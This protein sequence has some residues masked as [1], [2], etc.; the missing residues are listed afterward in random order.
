VHRHVH[1]TKLPDQQPMLWVGHPL[2]D[3]RV[4]AVRREQG[5]ACG[6]DTQ[7]GRQVKSAAK[8]FCCL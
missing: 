3:S 2:G 6:C 5:A 4:R 7:P 1:V 8:F